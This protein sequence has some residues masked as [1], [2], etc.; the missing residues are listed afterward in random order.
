MT[1]CCLVIMLR[2][3]T[4]V[5]GQRFSL[6]LLCFTVKTKLGRGW[7]VQRESGLAAMRADR[8]TWGPEWERVGFLFCG[9]RWCFQNYKTVCMCFILTS[10][11]R[12]CL[13]A[14]S[15]IVARETKRQ[16]FVF[17]FWYENTRKGSTQR[18]KHK[19]GSK[20][21]IVGC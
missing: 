13:K 9:F 15:K 3:E 11:W 17:S 20:I 8:A 7:I 4:S 12:V 14:V 18:H 5:Q 19:L 6:A 1:C 10:H 16:I 2:F 21:S